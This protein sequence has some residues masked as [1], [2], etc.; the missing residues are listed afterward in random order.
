MSWQAPWPDQWQ[1]DWGFAALKYPVLLTEVG[2]AVP[3]GR[4]EHVPVIGDE[5][6]GHA[7]GLSALLATRDGCSL[8][9]A[10]NR[11]LVPDPDQP[12]GFQITNTYLLADD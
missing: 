4:G 9:L 2:F 10:Y 5:Q 1:A 11:A 12:T 3:G 6:Y 8:G 7:L